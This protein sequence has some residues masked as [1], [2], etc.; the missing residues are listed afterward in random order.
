[1][2]K[3]LQRYAGAQLDCRTALSIAMLYG[4]LGTT[5][6][7]DDTTADPGANSDAS[8]ASSVVDGGALDTATSPVNTAESA[9]SE[10]E[11]KVGRSD[12]TEGSQATNASDSIS[13]ET[14]PPVSETSESTPVDTADGTTDSTTLLAT[15]SEPGATSESSTATASSESPGVE[16]ASS[17]SP[18]PG[19]NDPTG[20]NDQT[21]GPTPTSDEEST[22][23]CANGCWIDGACFA[24]GTDHPSDICSVCRPNESQQAWSS[25]CL[26]SSTCVDWDGIAMCACPSGLTGDACERCLIY[27]NKA[28]GDDEADGR[29][30][31][32]AFATVATAL[33]AAT[34]NGCEVWVAQGTYYPEPPEGNA[35][36]ATFSLQPGVDLY[37][38]FEGDEVLR[39]QREVHDRVTTLSGDLSH[40]DNPEE[41]TSYDDNAYHVVTGANDTRIDGFT[42]TAGSSDYGGGGM[43]NVSVSPLVVN[44]TFQGNFAQRGGAIYGIGSASIFDECR[45]TNNLASDHG[46]AYFSY[47][48]SEQFL[49][50][51]FVGNQA[52]DGS[53]GALAVVSGGDVN[54]NGCVVEANTA[55]ND[56]GAFSVASSGLNVRNTSF[57]END[58]ELSGGAIAA[59][60]AGSNVFIR[61][62]GFYDNQ[63]IQGGALV[64]KFGEP[65]RTRRGDVRWQ[66]GAE[67]W[68]S[69]LLIG[70]L[71]NR[72]AT[73]EFA[74]PR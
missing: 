5:L 41:T 35:R 33:Q 66:L 73:R 1:M 9:T 37:G 48:G 70:L 29:S 10:V 25:H 69:D 54:L 6:G 57:T 61:S 31:N 27:V 44:C 11:S 17:T 14:A 65:R 15:T 38:G 62:S 32:T 16:S 22:A 67:C 51:S 47:T 63:G 55:S 34:A 56:G 19:S 43:Y 23:A 50:T 58:S 71:G 8:A 42:I 36:A 40:N 68:W 46:G 52:A 12:R 13:V 28:T 3:V 53:G 18:N 74:L 60:G 7:C 72:R 2:T 30:W 49:A 39:L 24:E 64:L 4:A 45:F 20:T 21:N 59:F 26:D